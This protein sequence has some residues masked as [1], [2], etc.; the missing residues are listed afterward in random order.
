MQPLVSIM[1]AAHNEEAFIGDMIESILRQS[2][3]NFELLVA[4]D[5]ST[6]ATVE[7]ATRFAST[8][9]RVRVLPHA[10]LA[11][12]NSAWNRAYEYSNG[13]ILVF[14]GGDDLMP[15]DA[16]DLRVAAFGDAVLSELIAVFSKS[17]SFSEDSRFNGTI[18]P[19]GNV[20]SRSGPTTALSRGMADL[21]FPL[22]LGLPNED[23]WTSTL[24]ELRADHIIELP[25]VTLLYRIHSGN[26][27]RRDINF[28]GAQ[29]L[30]A[31]RHAVFTEL[32]RSD[33]FHWHRLEREYLQARQLLE[34]HRRA[35]AW[36]RILRHTGV[37]FMMRLR[38]LVYTLE[39]LYLIRQRFFKFFSGWSRGF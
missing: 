9:P 24:I 16:L 27:V 11:G 13:S 35:G 6:D 25:A 4:S 33:R 37:P 29:E 12:K 23:M 28:V 34:E 39:G 38:T 1:C 26:T 10:D 36:R 5:R 19:R 8:D 3:S 20:G 18:V 7:V 15:A 2:Y 32:L 14:M 31:R 17:K 22:P 30:I 21:V